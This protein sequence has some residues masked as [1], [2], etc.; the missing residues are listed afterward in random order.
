MY[1]QQHQ[2]ENYTYQKVLADTTQMYEK[3]IADLKKQLEVEHAR[4]VSAKEE[5]EVTKKILCDHKKSIQV[6]KFIGLW[7]QPCLFF[8]VFSYIFIIAILPSRILNIS[9]NCEF[10]IGAKYFS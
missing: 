8:T 3:N 6:S 1:C 4:S 9:Y 2:L 7:W 10:G 5:L